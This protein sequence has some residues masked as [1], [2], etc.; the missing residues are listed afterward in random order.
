ML[1]FQKTQKFYFLNRMKYVEGSLMKSSGK[2][3][4]EHE[5]LLVQKSRFQS[6]MAEKDV[7]VTIKK[8]DLVNPHRNS[9]FH[10]LFTLKKIKGR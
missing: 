3:S 10:M 2:V 8:I 5:R 6:K 4:A 9:L 1:A 7:K